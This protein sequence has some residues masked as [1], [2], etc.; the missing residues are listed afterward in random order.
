[1]TF[2]T[3]PGTDFALLD[4]MASGACGGALLRDYSADWSLG[5]SGDPM[6]YYCTYSGNGFNLNQN[7]LAMPVNSNTVGKLE[8]NAMSRQLALAMSVGDYSQL[9]AA[10]PLLLAHATHH[11]SCSTHRTLHR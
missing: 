7:L 10:R 2:L 1:M 6:G 11:P 8:A 4:A 5:P 9:Y 3:V